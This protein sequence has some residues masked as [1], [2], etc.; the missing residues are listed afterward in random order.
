MPLR[1]VG[2]LHA[3]RWGDDDFSAA[4][5]DQ[6]WPAEGPA[7][8]WPQIPTFGFL[9]VAGWIGYVGRDYLIRVKEE[10]KP[11]DKE[12]II[13]VPLAIKVALGGLGWPAKAIGELR[14]GTLLVRHRRRPPA[15]A[16]S[17]EHL[18]DAVYS[19][20]LY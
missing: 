18:K 13:D 7:A 20:D 19:M 1:G 12:I 16:L 11:T 17:F 9:Y 15:P 10:K 2:G 14:N 3:L 6:E 5:C 8:L 4:A